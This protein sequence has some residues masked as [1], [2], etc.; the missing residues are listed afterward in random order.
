[1]VALGISR[2]LHN[3][4]I[5]YNIEVYFIRSVHTFN[6]NSITVNSVPY[7]Q[8]YGTFFYVPNINPTNYSGVIDL[9]AFMQYCISN[10]L[11][12]PNDIIRNVRISGQI[13]TG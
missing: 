1:M 7:F 4:D 10:N 13:T 12:N 11:S 9:E 8:N 2:N 3:E 5:D 6:I